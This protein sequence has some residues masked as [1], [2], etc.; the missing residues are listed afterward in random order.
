MVRLKA[1]LHVHIET[2]IEMLIVEGFLIGL[3]SDEAAY[4]KPGT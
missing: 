1:T 4:W 3:F 2:E